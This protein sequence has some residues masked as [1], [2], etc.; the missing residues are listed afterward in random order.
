MAQGV[1]A[2]DD[3]RT[4][5]GNYEGFEENDRKR[6][7]EDGSPGPSKRRTRSAVKKEDISA[8][9]QQIQTLQVS[10]TN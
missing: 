10:G 6:A 3:V 9:T 8:L 2:G 5:K 4:G 1:I 7:R